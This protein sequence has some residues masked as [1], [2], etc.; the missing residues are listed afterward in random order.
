MLN[1]SFTLLRYTG[2]AIYS[3]ALLYPNI[4]IDAPVLAG[5]EKMRKTVMLLSCLA[6]VTVPCALARSASANE[7][8]QFRQEMEQLRAEHEQL[9]GEHE[10]L[11]AE[12]EQLRQREE[13]LHQR[14]EYLRKRGEEL[15]KQ[16]E[17]AR[18][19][20]HGSEHFVQGNIPPQSP[21]Q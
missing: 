3:Y 21:P 6:L 10:K 8:P 7:E 13:Q 20:H 4:F 19:Q 15:H 12:M 16:M 5:E 9:R 1:L 17:L 2:A 18:E 14:E 11:H